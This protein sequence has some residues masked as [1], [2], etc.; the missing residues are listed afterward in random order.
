[1]SRVYGTLR[2]VLIN[3][4]TGEIDLQRGFNQ[5]PY[6]FDRYDFKGIDGKIQGGGKAFNFYGYNTGHV[7]VETNKRP[8][9]EKSINFNSPIHYDIK[10]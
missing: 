4:N 1:M 7:R 10:N 9:N 3:P 8:D 6:A 5:D 2:I